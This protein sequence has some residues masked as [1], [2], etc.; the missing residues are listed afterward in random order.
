MTNKNM[1]KKEQILAYIFLIP[2]G[3]I[4]LVF[5]IFP[6]FYSWWISLFNWDLILKIKEFTG[7]KNYVNL[8]SDFEFWKSLFN[9]F[10]FALG[11]IPASIIISL[12]IAICL[13]SKI[14]G[15]SFYRTVYFLPVITS[16]NAVAMI[17]LYIYHPDT[18]LLNYLLSLFNISSQ[19][20]LLDPVLAMPAVILMSIW[21]NLGYD[22]IIFLVGLQSIPK[23]YYEAA[24]IDGANTFKAFKYITLPLLMPTLFFV[25]I[26]SLISSFHTFTQV[27]MLTRDGG[28]LHSTSVIVYYLYEN[29]FV[30]QKMSYACTVSVVIFIIVFSLTLIQ[31]KFWGEKVHYEV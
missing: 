21:K 16:I 20:W 3:V 22:I 23:E 11:T 14:R 30:F 18:G 12:I 31:Y 29:A 1:K 19:K 5:Y 25:A 27:F 4:I 7:I 6:T 2:A 17:W 13:N 8:F 28:P 24:Q 26:V 15:L 9:T 10:Y